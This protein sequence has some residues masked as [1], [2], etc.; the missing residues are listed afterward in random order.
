M[1]SFFR[2]ILWAQWLLFK[3]ACFGLWKGQFNCNAVEKQLI[4]A[5]KIKIINITPL[6]PRSIDPMT[7]ILFVN[8]RGFADFF[9]DGY[10]AGGASSLSR[11]MVMVALPMV[12]IY[13]LLTGRG[14]FF[15][16]GGTKRSVLSEKI[17]THLDRYKKPIIIYPEGMRYLGEK[18]IELRHGALRITYENN[19]SC[20]ILIASGKEKIVNE[21]SYTISKQQTCFY[22]ISSVIIP[23][24][25]EKYEDFYSHIAKSWAKCWEEAYTPNLLL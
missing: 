16:R 7:K 5:L 19:L 13:G 10:L 15:N 9:L 12:G 14:L 4:E 21:K 2:F 20:Q 23:H 17:L 18:P 6:E 1:F 24:S 8:H 25:F 3:D 22:T 11:Y